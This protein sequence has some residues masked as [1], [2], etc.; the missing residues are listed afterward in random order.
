[1]MLRVCGVGDF[2]GVS[3][4]ANE[5]SSAHVHRRHSR[6]AQ[7]GVWERV[8]KALSTDADNE[9]ALIDATLVRAHQHA[10]GGK[11]GGPRS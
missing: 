2:A 9:Y 7:R 3:D 8:F 4:P 11:K 1:M 10:A 5:K 6:W